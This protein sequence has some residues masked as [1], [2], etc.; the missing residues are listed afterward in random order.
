MKTYN[1]EKAIIS[2]TSWKARIN[3]VHRVIAE[4]EF[5]NKENNL[6]RSLLRFVDSNLIEILWIE[7]NYKAFKKVLFTMEKYPNVP[8]ISADD[9]CLY[10]FNY[11][12]QLYQEWLKDKDYVISTSSSFGSGFGILFQ[13]K[14]FKNFRD[15][16][17]DEIVKTNHDDLFYRFLMAKNGASQ[18]KFFVE[19]KE[20]DR[21]HVFIDE[22]NGVSS[23]IREENDIEI[24]NKVFKLNLNRSHFSSKR[25]YKI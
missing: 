8:V 1:N 25:Q 10:T 11:A 23:N 18:Y 6:P 5:P 21:K 14:F 9:D 4:E 17:T 2:L 24:F 20:I 12:E 15:Y 7:K 19:R 22:E 16:L 13:Y 3:I